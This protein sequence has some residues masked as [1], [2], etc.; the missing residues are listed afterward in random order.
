MPKRNDEEELYVLELQARV[1]SVEN[2]RCDLCAIFHFTDV[3]EWRRRKWFRS[4][5]DKAELP[6]H[7]GRKGKP[8]QFVFIRVHQV[9]QDGQGRSYRRVPAVVWLHPFDGIPD[10]LA[11]RPDSAFPVSARPELVFRVTDRKLQSGVIGGR[12]GAGFVDCDC[13]NQVVQTGAQIVEAVAENE[14]PAFEGWRGRR[15]LGKNAIACTVL[16]DVRDGFVWATLEPRGDFVIDDAQ[17][18]FRPVQFGATTA[19]IQRHRWEYDWRMKSNPKHSAEFQNFDNAMQ[20]VLSVS[21]EELQRRLEADKAAHAGQK[22]RG[23]KPKTSASDHAS[24][25]TV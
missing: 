19:D 17:M 3:S 24:D 8:H 7:H 6:L 15:L 14:A 16:I 10:I 11:K 4:I 25:K 23:P 5:S 12:R 18:F 13:I 20:R 1:R 21:K 2:Y 9:S 22:K